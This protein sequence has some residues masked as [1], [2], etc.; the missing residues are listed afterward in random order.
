VLTLEWIE[1]PV[2]YAHAVKTDGYLLLRRTGIECKDFNTKF[3]LATRTDN[4]SSRSY[5]SSVRRSVAKKVKCKGKGRALDDE[6]LESEGEV[7]IVSDI[8]TSSI[9]PF[10]FYS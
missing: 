5:M 10:R 1:C 8:S 2:L 9:I 4:S 7:E 3:S 6:E